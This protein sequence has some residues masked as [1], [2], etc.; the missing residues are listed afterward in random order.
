M[1]DNLTSNEKLSDWLRRWFVF[2]GDLRFRKAADEIERLS[3][4]IV[5]GESIRMALVA[6]LDGLRTAQPPTDHRDKTI[7]ALCDRLERINKICCAETMSRAKRLREIE[8][9]SAGFMQI[10]PPADHWDA[11]GSPVEIYGIDPAKPGSDRTAYC[12]Q[13]GTGSPVE[14]SEPLR[15]SDVVAGREFIWMKGVPGVHCKVRVNEVRHEPNGD[16]RVFTTALQ[17][18]RWNAAGAVCWNDMSRFLEAC[19]PVS[20]G[21]SQ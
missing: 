12:C 13:D 8:S 5:E 16:V 7:T 3:G 1:T 20:E 19:T 11:N 4:A 6:E 2:K 15:A 18:S 10:P 17:S 21:E 9:E 14:T